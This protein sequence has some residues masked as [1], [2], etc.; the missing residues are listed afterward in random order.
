MMHLETFIKDNLPQLKYSVKKEDFEIYGKD[1]TN[2]YLPKPSIIVFPK[3]TEEVQ[4]IVKLANKNNIG[5]VP[6]GGRTGLSGGA[7]AKNG[8]IVISLD[9]MNRIIEFNEVNQTLK[10]EAGV[11][12]EEIQKIAKEKG[13][14]YPVDFA[15]RG[16]SHIGGNI[17]TNAGGI[18][19]L[20]YGLTRNWITGIKMVIGNGEV[21]NTNKGLLK[22][23]TGYDLRH[24]IIGSEGSLGIVTEAIVKLTK[25][26][27]NVEV[28]FFGISKID[29]V[30][31]ILK[32]F[33]RQINISA[34]E[35]V[36]HGTLVHSAR[37]AELPLPF[38]ESYPFYVLIEFENTSDIIGEKIETIVTNLYKNNFISNDL[39]GGNAN[40][41]ERI[42]SYRER[43]AEAVAPFTPYKNDVSVLT[44]DI[45]SFIKE[46]EQLLEKAYPNFEV[47]WYGHIADGNLHINILKPKN[48][49]IDDFHKEG[50]RVS[51][52]LFTLIEKYE[53]SISAEHGLGLL[54]KDFIHHSRSNI[55]IELMKSI[56]K[57]FDPKGIM[58]PNKVF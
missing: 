46:A 17:A 10:V 3:S 6:S 25:A 19:V 55:E 12:T 57:I 51:E 32:M 36:S 38:D 11:V 2:F 52:I 34:F 49:S 7:V 42:W 50:D 53:G 58:N 30:L 54:K 23:A 27:E 35:F 26:P 20:R 16:S 21:I 22:N 9:Y 45:P 39:Y 15:S 24:L 1:W 4:A 48:I 56:K 33:K 8:E 13:L 14:Y 5:I 47:V 41:I 37:V 18:R 43:A 29:N 44:S 28:L 40:E 31:P